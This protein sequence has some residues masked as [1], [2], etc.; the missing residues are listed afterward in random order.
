VEI[1]VV[2]NGAIDASLDAPR[3]RRVISDLFV[4]QKQERKT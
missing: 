2:M 4:R 3:L 1:S